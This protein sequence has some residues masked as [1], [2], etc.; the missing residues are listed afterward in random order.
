MNLSAKPETTRLFFR[1]LK[2]MASVG[3]LPHEL[4]APQPL[5]FNI[6]LEVPRSVASSANDSIDEVFDYR[7]IHQQ[8]TTLVNTRHFNLLETLADE[9]LS[10]LLQ[11]PRVLA[12]NLELHKTQPYADAQS[13]GIEVCGVRERQ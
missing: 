12:V 6:D 2:V 11:D 8:V 5:L 1:Q 3:V 7:V 10:T 13:V 9:L 4:I